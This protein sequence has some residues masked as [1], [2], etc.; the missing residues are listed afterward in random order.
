[1]NTRKIFTVAAVLIVLLTFAFANPFSYNDATTRTVVT[2][3]SGNQ[4]VRYE[5]GAFWAGFFAKEVTYPNQIGIS[6]TESEADYDLIDNTIEVGKA[7]IQFSDGTTALCDGIAQYILPTSE[8]EMLEVHNAHRSPEGLVKRRLAPYTQECLSASAQLLSSEMHY[9]GGKAQMTQDYL[10]QLQNGSY[11][12]SVQEVNIYDSTEK[13]NKKLYVVKI[14]T[15]KSTSQPKRKFS[16]IKEY[17]I[18]VGDAQITHT[19]YEDKVDQMLAKKI[20]AATKASIS[21]QELMTAQQQQ[22]TAEAVGKKT[23]VEIEYKQKQQQTVQVVQAQTKVELAKQDL[24]QQEIQRQASEKEAA[25]IKTLADAE[26]YARQRVMAADG[27][28]DKK[29]EAYKEVQGYWADAFSKYQGS[30]VPQFQTGG[31]SNNTNGAINF[32]EIM[33]AKAAKDLSLQLGNK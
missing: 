16:S 25:K 1:M 3:L 27:A 5:S 13:V 28:L 21:R 12:L 8:K 23:L 17:G 9:S 24:I 15:D 29:L 32:M 14:Q 18:T 2:Q 6:Y 20:D 11:L 33:G 22:L 7:R 19:D 26:A 31:G 30:I 4:F 10:N